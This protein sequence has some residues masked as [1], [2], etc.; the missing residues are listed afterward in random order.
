ME[1]GIFETIQVGHRLFK[2]ERNKYSRWGRSLIREA[3]RR[4]LLLHRYH[5]CQA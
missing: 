1:N 2:T 4:G 3:R 5:T